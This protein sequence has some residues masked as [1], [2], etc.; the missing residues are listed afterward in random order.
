MAERILLVNRFFGGAQTPTGRMLQDVAHALVEAG[1]HV[2]VLTS[3]AA[4]AGVDDGMDDVAVV[5]VRTVWTPTRGQLG[6]W[7]VFLV[8]AV[9]RMP[10]L[11]WD[12][13]V[14]LT[15]PPM[16]LAAA[17]AMRKRNRRLYWWT[18]DLY[19]EALVAH[20]MVKPNGFAHR[21]L[22]RVNDS[23]LRKVDGV[24]TLGA[25]QTERLQAYAS[26]PEDAAENYVEVSPWDY[27]PLPRVARA[28]NAFL[29]AMGWQN[30]LVAL[31][32]GNIGAAH[33][34]EEI[35]AAARLHASDPLSR[36]VFAFVV[37]GPRRDALEEAAADLPNVVVLDYLPPE[38]S[39]DLLWSADVHIITMRTGWE[40]IVVPSKLYGVL[41]TDA[42]V[43]FIGP[44]TA[45]TALEITRL[46]RGEVLPVEASAVEVSEALER[47]CDRPPMLASHANRNAPETIAAFVTA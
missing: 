10:F 28:D 32:A 14:L 7:I 20:G 42:P 3:K 8:Q 15:D 19:P 47:L 9:L 46:G 43:L 39:A 44:L 34:F 16:L 26:W 21:L 27:R 22:V 6:S 12:R 45:D 35:L 36:W 40:G 2:E 13:C 24:V 25:C 30:R 23:A 4:Y 1:H 38:Q 5:R 41:M 11:K 29:N 17:L 33:C 31:Y 18:M 37:R